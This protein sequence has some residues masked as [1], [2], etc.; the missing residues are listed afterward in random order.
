M[1]GGSFP[2]DWL[3]GAL[4]LCVLA[5]LAESASYGY[6]IA[7]RLEAAGLGAVKGGTLYPLLARLE[8]AGLVAPSWRTGDG[9]PSRKY[10]EL[11]D[12]GRAELVHRRDLWRQFTASV[13]RLAYPLE[14]G[15][16][17]A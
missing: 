15:G 12:A 4:D 11:T 6:A 17:H 8:A 2:A 14:A 13:D 3:R 9:G 1:P 7:Q 5:I 10:L 16:R